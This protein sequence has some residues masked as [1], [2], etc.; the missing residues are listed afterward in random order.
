MQVHGSFSFLHASFLHITS[1]LYH[2]HVTV[3]L[4]AIIFIGDNLQYFSETVICMSHFIR[5]SKLF[6]RQ[7]LIHM[8]S[9]NF[10]H[11]EPRY[12]EERCDVLCLCYK[13]RKRF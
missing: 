13:A 4:L 1:L 5:S 8:L 3:L 9:L 7:S 11:R 12:S 6:P 2:V 10:T